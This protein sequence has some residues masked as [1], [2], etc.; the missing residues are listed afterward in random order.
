MQLL[1]MQ[2]IMNFL[3]SILFWKGGTYVLGP[4]VFVLSIC[5][6]STSVL[7]IRFEM[8]NL[9]FDI[10]M[11]V[12]LI[13]SFKWHQALWSCDL[14]SY[15]LDFVAI[16]VSINKCQVDLEHYVTDLIFTIWFGSGCWSPQFPRSWKYYYI[17]WKIN[18]YNNFWIVKKKQELL[19]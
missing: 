12:L 15:R 19:F 18:P 3:L 2:S 17:W 9:T 10:Y 11:Y 13:K 16:R 7:G 6:L 1:F 8:G 14:D 4:K 5:L